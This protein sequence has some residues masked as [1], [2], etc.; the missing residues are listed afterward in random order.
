MEL[1][2][3]SAL[4]LADLIRRRQ[5][6]VTEAVKDTLDQIDRQEK[7]IHAYLYICLLYTSRCV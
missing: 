1:G 2:K 5:I 7:E 6:S 3:H 4:E